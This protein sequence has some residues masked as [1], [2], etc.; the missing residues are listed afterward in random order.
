M[1]EHVLQPSTCAGGKTPRWRMQQCH[2]RAAKRIFGTEPTHLG[3]PLVV[4]GVP[5]AMVARLVLQRSCMQ[6]RD[7]VSVWVDGCSTVLFCSSN[8]SSAFATIEDIRMY[9]ALPCRLAY[10]STPAAL[11]RP[12]PPR[13]PLP[14]PAPSPQTSYEAACAHHMWITEC[15]AIQGGASFQE[16]E[17]R[18]QQRDDT[19]EARES[20]C[21][22]PCRP[23][24]PGAA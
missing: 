10:G 8:S 23:A 13:L 9:F 18:S 22:R 3:V 14:P 7:T 24:M 16:R 20:R 15:Q 12:A 1:Q 21:P 2:G 4:A 17:G 6:S 19:V 11:C 5:H